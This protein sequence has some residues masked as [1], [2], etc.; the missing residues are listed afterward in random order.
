[1]RLHVNG[2]S[3]NLKVNPRSTATH[4]RFAPVLTLQY[5]SLIIATVL[6][7]CLLSILLS[8]SL[9]QLPYSSVIAT[10]DPTLKAFIYFFGC[11]ALVYVGFLLYKPV[12]ALEFNKDTG[13]FWIE[14]QLVFGWK[15]GES[16]QMPV[17]QVC[18]LQIL[19]YAHPDGINYKG[20]V[21]ATEHEVNVVF[22]NGARVNVMNHSNGRA[23]RQDA[24]ALAAFLDVPVHDCRQDEDKSYLPS[25]TVMAE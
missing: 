15:T 18:A 6:L 1:M 17:A 25:S 19:S 11:S 14:K 20:H 5:T 23:I 10:L 24:G 13:V 16:A 7:V 4:L 21:S 2:E 22:C 12:R 3:R 8:G 9:P